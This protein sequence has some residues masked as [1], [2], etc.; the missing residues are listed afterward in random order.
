MSVISH[1]SDLELIAQK[2]KLPKDSIINFAG[3]VNPYG[4]SSSVKSNLK[5]SLDCISQYPDPSYTELKA[6]LSSY[7]TIP[8]H[9]ILVGNGTTELISLAIKQQQAKKALIL[10]PTYSEYKRELN[11]AS[12]ALDEY[13]LNHE[14]DFTLD[15]DDLFQTLD[16]GYD[17]LILCNPNNPTG[18]AFRKD[19][20]HDLLKYCM[21]KQIFIMVDETYIEFSSNYKEI[22]SITLTN[23][24]HNLLVLRGFSKFFAAPGLRLGYGVCSNQNLIHNIMEQQNPWSINSIAEIAPKYLLTDH[25]YIQDTQ[26]LINSERTRI[27]K[28]FLNSK[29]F[30][31]YQTESNFFLLKILA[32]GYS[33]SSIFEECI[34]YGLF[35]R[36]CSSFFNGNGE[37]IRFCILKK[38]DNDKLLKVLT[39][40]EQ[41]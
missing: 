20:L 30:Y 38:E 3:N 36:D 32:D 41:R 40:L 27:Y 6:N 8:A 18:K 26:E 28:H 31:C 2:Y 37:F 13:L 9:N 22:E 34:K 11:L 24:Y 1:G 5:H 29:L 21:K 4:L 10:G 12:C 25:N 35:L 7:L 14:D 39:N 19:V 16:H 23:E 17:F 15:L 33:S